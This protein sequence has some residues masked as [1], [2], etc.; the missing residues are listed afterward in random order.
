VFPS[1][2][3]RVP[4]TWLPQFRHGEIVPFH[5]YVDPVPWLA[6]EPWPA[7]CRHGPRPAVGLVDTHRRR[8]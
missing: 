7:G 3:F 2:I 5:D 4:G 6:E 8:A 1:W